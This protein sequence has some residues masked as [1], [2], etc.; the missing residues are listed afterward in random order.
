LEANSQGMIEILRKL[1]SEIRYFG[2]QSAKK[3]FPG[4]ASQVSESFKYIS[5]DI[6][7]KGNY[8]LFTL[9]INAL[10]YLG[11]E[12][13]RSDLNG[14]AHSAVNALFSIIKTTNDITDFSDRPSLRIE[15]ANRLKDIGT[16]AAKK[17]QSDVSSLAAH[18]FGYFSDPSRDLLE[19]MKTS[20]EKMLDVSEDSTTCYQ[21]ALVLNAFGRFES[22][23]LA[24]KAAK[25][26]ISKNSDHEL[27]YQQLCNALRIQEIHYRNKREDQEA[28][29]KKAEADAACQKYHELHNRNAQR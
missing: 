23:D 25:K 3:N 27:A 11:L 28:D 15:I 10:G 16:E 8:N 6:G 24:I 29:A 22:S 19:I 1:I 14:A 9:I 18:S 4:T 2:E 5:K 13:V 12:F 26:A 20:L 21:I 7:E 17:N